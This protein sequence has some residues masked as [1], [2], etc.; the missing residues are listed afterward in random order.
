[1]ALQK[2]QKSLEK[3]L[4]RLSNAVTSVPRFSNKENTE[5]FKHQF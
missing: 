2:D 1:M 4:N 3:Q 5:E